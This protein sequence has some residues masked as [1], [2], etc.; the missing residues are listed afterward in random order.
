M[1]RSPPL[2]IPWTVSLGSRGVLA[3][4][5]P[6]AASGRDPQRAPQVQPGITPE[7][8]SLHG[9]VACPLHVSSL[10]RDAVH[11]Y[12]ENRW[13]AGRMPVDGLGVWPCT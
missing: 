2:E 12:R 10:S 1:S 5:H 3:V 6:P 4:V 7:M 8:T 9:R 11:G 13:R